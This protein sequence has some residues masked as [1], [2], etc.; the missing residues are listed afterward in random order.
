[1][2]GLGANLQMIQEQ[3]GENQLYQTHTQEMEMQDD[4]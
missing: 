2:D 3:E 1:M 4:S